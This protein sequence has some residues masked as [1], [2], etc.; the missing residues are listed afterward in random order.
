M[1]SEDL[2][3]RQ[4]AGERVEKDMIAFMIQFH[5]THE[6]RVSDLIAIASHARRL[7]FDHFSEAGTA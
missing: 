6:L 5:P 2:K 7:A 1:N 3:R 4:Q